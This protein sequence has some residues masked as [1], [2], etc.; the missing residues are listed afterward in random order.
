VFEDP[1]AFNITRDPNKHLAFGFGVHFCLGAPLAR[2]EAKSAIG[3]LLERSPDLE[4][5][6][7]RSEL[8]WHPDFFLRGVK[9]I[10]VVG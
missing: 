4:L 1:D 3:Q 9:S 10:P 8:E 5:A 2:L 6:V 7:D